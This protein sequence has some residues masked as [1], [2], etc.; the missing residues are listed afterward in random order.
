MSL[1]K[2]LRERY[3][4]GKLFYKKTGR[5]CFFVGYNELNKTY[6][7]MLDTHELIEISPNDVDFEE[8]N[9]NQFLLISLAIVALV[10]IAFIIVLT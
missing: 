1:S 8:G 2:E 9:A 4:K 7:V 5:Q 6:L 3:K 10:F